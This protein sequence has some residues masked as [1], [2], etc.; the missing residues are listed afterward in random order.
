MP[1]SEF[2]LLRGEFFNLEA[3]IGPFAAWSISGEL[4][5]TL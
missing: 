4:I 2:I 5:L 1:K 3:Y